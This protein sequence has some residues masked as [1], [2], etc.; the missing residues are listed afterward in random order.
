M[1]V[2]PVLW[3]CGRTTELPHACMPRFFRCTCTCLHVHAVDSATTV[4][5]FPADPLN[6]GLTD[7]QMYTYALAAGFDGAWGWA[8][9]GDGGN[10]TANLAPAMK[11]IRVS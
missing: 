3:F 10:S 5:E 1:G 4:G 7:T 2:G 6:G 8:M 11:A 9:N